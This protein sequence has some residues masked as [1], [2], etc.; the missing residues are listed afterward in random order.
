MKNKIEDKKIRES[1]PTKK[2]RSRFPF[3]MIPFLE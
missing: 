3:N 2:D 1:I